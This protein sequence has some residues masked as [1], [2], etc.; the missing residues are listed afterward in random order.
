M[1]NRKPLFSSNQNHYRFNEQQNGLRTKID[2]VLRW[3]FLILGLYVVG[4]LIY[5]LVF[6]TTKVLV[7][8]GCAHSECRWKE[9]EKSEFVEEFG[10]LKWSLLDE[11]RKTAVSNQTGRPLKMIS[12]AYGG[13]GIG[14]TKKT[15]PPGFHIIDDRPDY[16]MEESPSYIKTRGGG[17]KSTIRWELWC[18]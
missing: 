3:G 16:L 1:N 14:G 8:T 18:N 17:S 5:T 12:V 13:Y 10:G 4:G 6:P 11:K 15:I 7:V 9:Y 2:S